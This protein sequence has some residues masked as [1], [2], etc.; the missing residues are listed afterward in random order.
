MWHHGKWGSAF[1]PGAGLSGELGSEEPQLMQ[2]LTNGL[3]RINLP[4]TSVNKA[5]MEAQSC[6]RWHHGGV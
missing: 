4:D 5:S 3:R 6:T 2:D 1:G